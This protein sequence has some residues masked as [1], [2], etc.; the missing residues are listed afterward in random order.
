MLTTRRRAPIA[1]RP[2]RSLPPL[3]RRRARPAAPSS[4]AARSQVDVDECKD[5]AAQYGVKS[6]PTFKFI[7]GG[8]E[9]DEMKGA[10]EGA[11][12]E[13][14]F[15]LAGSPDRWASAGSGRSL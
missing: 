2:R 14:I 11:L 13:K 3:P 4:A 5:L 8:K 7:K 15:E 1:H 9:V 6:M 10:D 12:R